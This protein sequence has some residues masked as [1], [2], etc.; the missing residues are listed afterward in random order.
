[1]IRVA[2]EMGNFAHVSSYVTRAETLPELTDPVLIAK[3]KVASG[4]SFLANK[5]YNIA[6]RKFLEVTADLGSNY[7]EVP[8]SLYCIHRLAH[9]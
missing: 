3:L 7:L 8:S 1:M 4:L 9:F 6:A 2:I 5:K